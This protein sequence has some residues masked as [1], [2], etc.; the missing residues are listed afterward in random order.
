M[1]ASA[2]V[3]GVSSVGEPADGVASAVRLRLA[4]VLRKLNRP[5]VASVVVG[6]SDLESFRTILLQLL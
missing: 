1:T 5:L 2:V 6:R 4:V 3:E